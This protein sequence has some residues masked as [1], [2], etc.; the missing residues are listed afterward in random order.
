MIL[1]FD[2][3][4]SDAR[5]LEL[6][7]KINELNLKG[8]HYSDGSCRKSLDSSWGLSAGLGCYVC[9]AVCLAP[10]RQGARELT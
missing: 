8:K 5:P 10:N 9:R 7:K 4:L 1:S 3:D 2:K 6:V